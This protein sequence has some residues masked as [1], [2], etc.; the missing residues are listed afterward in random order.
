MFWC[1]VEIFIM[2]W[3][4]DKVWFEFEYFYQLVSY[5]FGIVNQ[6]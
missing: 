4:D 1:K 5:Q 6:C 2:E 3:V